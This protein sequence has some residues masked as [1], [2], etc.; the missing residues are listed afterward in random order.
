MRFYT[1][2]HSFYCGVDLHARTMYVCILDDGTENPE[3]L[4]QSTSPSPDPNH[5]ERFARTLPMPNLCPRLRRP[6]GSTALLTVVAFLLA[7]SDLPAQAPADRAAAEPPLPLEVAVSLRG[8]NGRSPVNVSPDGRWLAHTVET[9]DTVPQGDSRAFA[10]TGFPFAEGS[11]RMEATLTATDGGETVR[12][13]S[14][15]ASS[16]AA[17]WSPDGSRV[18]FY[19]DESGE[20]GLWIWNRRSGDR[21]RVGDFVVRPFFGFEAVRWLD[22]GRHVVVKL[23]PEGRTL[24]EQNALIPSPT[25]N[26]PAPEIEPG[27]PSVE[28]RRSTAAREEE[29]AEPRE[30]EHAPG[31]G[32]IRE[33]IRGFV[34]D[35]AVVDVDTGEA[36][37]IVHGRSV[38]MYALSPDDRTV[39]YTVLTGVVPDTQQPLFELHRF[40]LETGTDALLIED[41]HLGYGI[42]WSWSPDGRRIAYTRSGVGA[43]GRFM[44]V[45]VADAKVRALEY[46]APSFAPDEGEA[47]PIWS[48]DGNVLYG[49]G[50][51]ALW[52]VD[53]QTAT[54]REIARVEGWNLRGP[55]TASFAS[56]VAWSNPSDQPTEPGGRLWL[57]ARN[58]EGDRSG[59]F[60]VDPVAGEARL[61]IQEDRS[62]S[63]LFSQ[64]V[65]PAAGRIF[66][67]ARSQQQPTE[68]W[69]F[70]VDSGRTRQVTGINAE[71]E[72][73]AL[74][75][76]RTIRWTS[77]RNEPLAGALLL[78]PDYRSGT[79]LPLVV[80]VYGGDYGS[81]FVGRFG[82][83]G[84]MA[85]F[86]MHVLASR[87]YAVLFPDAPLRPGKI[88]EDLVS[89]VLSGV[90]AAIDQGYAD[91]DRLAIMGQSFGA[92]NTLALLTKTHRFKAA[93]I[94]A[95]VQHPDLF[96]D[97]LRGTST[98]YWEEGQGGME[99]SIWE[100]HERY[101]ENSPVFD[102]PE[103]DTPLLIGQ[104]DQDGD[105][106]PAEA[107]FA[108]LERLGK[109]VEL[110]IYR[111]ESH[112]IS[113]DANVI[114]FWRR[115]LEFLS[116]SLNLEVDASGAVS[117]PDRAP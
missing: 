19:S 69:T 55:V 95:A 81:R 52:S 66:F 37:R 14:P 26:P 56:A 113:R 112:V 94:T 30:K 44:I 100:Q 74:G 35:L 11:S 115:R 111:G 34:A 9:A 45:D 89:S 20:A 68:L 77:H 97:Y 1:A 103:I 71:L 98:G 109:G 78:P 16:W 91:P 108:A 60:S 33:F 5:L 42:E 85:T 88:T 13:G 76:A 51:G 27:E 116:R 22:D 110:R 23:L 40:D 36:R 62:Y 28:V 39:A 87:G 15:D 80:F 58:T 90:D 96:A 7:P 92:L 84:G 67:A 79:R 99:G 59:I 48:A 70:E 18:A 21:R 4:Q 24:A 12:L 8:H 47:P 2:Q 102:F 31:R 65:D 106:V 32:A 114:D 41:A 3:L 6:I 107:I 82:L 105:L 75:E 61:E 57:F 50:D 93:V 38:R 43:D 86:N 53:P 72:R 104:G 73:Y 29:G 17:V 25:K 49:V 10:A 64:A 117:V 54:A 83:W 63:G 46:E 101:L